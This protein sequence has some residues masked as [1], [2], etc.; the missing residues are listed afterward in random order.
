M[1]VFWTGGEVVI[2]EYLPFWA[3][4]TLFCIFAV[5][6]FVIAVVMDNKDGEKK[7]DEPPVW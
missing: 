7:D 6:V 4:V 5:G 1:A 3:K 2:V